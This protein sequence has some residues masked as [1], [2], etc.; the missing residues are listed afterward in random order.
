MSTE[1]LEALRD[2]TVR[3]LQAQRRK[4]VR[5]RDAIRTDLERIDAAEE[6]AR[7]AALAVPTIGRLARGAT[8]VSVTDWATG[9]AVTHVIRLDP[10]RAPRETLERTFKN[11]RR[12][13][14]AEPIVEA[15]LRDVERAVAGL[16]EAIAAAASAEDEAALD[17]ARARMRLPLPK[18]P[19]ERAPSQRPKP[20]FRTF[21]T[22]QGDVWVGRGA[23]KND[24]LTFRVAKPYHLWLH[25]RGTPGAHVVVPVA[26]DRSVPSELLVDA[27]HLAVHFSDAKG[28]RTVEVSY[29]PRKFVRKPRG[30]APGLVTMEREKVLALRVDDARTEHLLTLETD[31]NA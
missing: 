8:E 24:E 25:V 11:A 20:P 7:V 4:L 26:R 13:R 22:P 6:E 1:D 10:T 3:S 29:V 17:E 16:E 21:R 5:K 12:L 28:E 30:A 15:R 23:A 19:G 9:K 31:Q 14:K 27:A 18:R 2:A